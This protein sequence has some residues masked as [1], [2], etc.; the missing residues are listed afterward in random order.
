MEHF[1][2]QIG[3]KTRACSKCKGDLGERYGKQRYCKT[4]HAAHMRATRPKHIELKEQARIKA[5]ARAYAKEYLKRGK[6]VKKPC[7]VCGSLE[8]Q[9]HHSDYS[10]PLLVEWYCRFHHLELHKEPTKK[11]AC[12]TPKTY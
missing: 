2:K 12:Q 3:I 10:K 9:M 7:V 6:L 4:C 8:S 1:G 11:Q 5:N